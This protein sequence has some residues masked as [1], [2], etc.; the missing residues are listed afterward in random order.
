MIDNTPSSVGAS[1][2]PSPSPSRSSSAS[3]PGSAPDGAASAT[4]ARPQ[5]AHDAA[6]VGV[7]P[8]PASPRRLHS[9]R[10]IRRLLRRVL[11]WRV[12]LPTRLLRRPVFRLLHAY[13]RIIR[14]RLVRR[15]AGSPAR[16]STPRPSRARRR[17][18]VRSRISNHRG[19]LLWPAAHHRR[20]QRTCVIAT[21]RC[22][23]SAPSSR[24]VLGACSTARAGELRS[25]RCAS[26]CPARNFRPE[27]GAPGQRAR[28]LQ[29][30][31]ESTPIG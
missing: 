4:P 31:Q 15:L 12:Q 16:R 20:P 14:R 6:D 18:S 26:A 30:L 23:D 11:R 1:G 28:T 21:R 25:A 5:V 24:R 8:W 2:S 7:P 22:R 13:C 27:P 17:A 19:G 29:Y 9:T 10:R 3:P